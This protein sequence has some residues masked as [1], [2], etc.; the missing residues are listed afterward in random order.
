MELQ[1]VFVRV[2]RQRQQ[3]DPLGHKKEPAPRDF[4]PAQVCDQG[5][6]LVAALLKHFNKRRR[7]FR[8]VHQIF[9]RLHVGAG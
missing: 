5:D 3:I 6:W 4:R 1:R 7:H 9:Q 8:S 2:R